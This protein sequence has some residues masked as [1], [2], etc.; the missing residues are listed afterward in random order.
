[1]SQAE[2]LSRDIPVQFS[3]D[4]AVLDRLVHLIPDELAKEIPQ[5]PLFAYAKTENLQDGFIEVSARDFARA[6]NSISW[7]LESN[8]GKPEAGSFPTIAYIGSRS[9]LTKLGEEDDLR[10]FLLAFG[11]VKVGYKM[12]F[13]SPRNSVAGHVNVL[14]KAKCDIF[15]VSKDIQIDHILSQRVMRRT[16]VVPELDYFL[17]DEPIAPYPYTKTFAE[18]REDPCLV[19][20]TTGSTGLPKPITWKLEILS[21][22]EAWRTIPSIDGYVPTTEVY[23]EATRAY[24]AMPL[25]HT[26]GIN[27]GI[28]MS[29]LLGITTVLGPANLLPNATFVNEMHKHAGIDASI[30]PPSTYEDLSQDPHAL[31][32][33][34]KLRYVLVCGAPLSEAV[35]D[36]LSDKTR[37]ISNFGAT[38][39]A[40][41]PRLSPAREDWAYF[42]WHPSHSGIQLREHSEGL[43]EL[44][45]ARKPELRS[46]QGIFSTFPEIQEYSMND[47]YSRHPDPSK[48]FL[49]RWQSRSDD[50][51][52]LSNGEK[53]A[54]ALMEAGL[55]GSPLVKG[56][57]VVG[58]GKFEPAALVDLGNSV[59]DK[60]EDRIA[61][62]ENLKTAIA[63]ANRYAP[64]HG[65]LDRYHIIIVDPARP[66]QYL[67]Q[68]KIQR[69]QTYELYKD[70]ID[71]L[72]QDTENLAP[73]MMLHHTRVDFG[74][75]MAIMQ[76]LE[77]LL[78]DIAG[79]QNPN[80]D[81]GLNAAGLDSLHIIRLVREFKIQIK[82]ADATQLKT[83]F[84][85]PNLIYQH[86][87]LKELADFFFDGHTG[88]KGYEIVTSNGEAGG[89]SVDKLE[90]M[91]NTLIKYVNLLPV[92]PM[93]IDPPPFKQHKTVL[94]T[95]STGSLGSYLLHQLFQ[96]PSVEYIFC[97]DRASGGAERYQKNRD[98]RGLTQLGSGR[99]EFIK[100]D[101]S[102]SKLGLDQDVYERLKRTVTHVV[103]SQWPVNFNWSLASFEP[104]IAG[105]VNLIQLAHESSRSAFILFL[106]S[107]AA[108]GGWRAHFNEHVPETP[109]YDLRAAA[110]TGYGQ[111]KLIA[112]CLLDRAAAVSGVRSASCRVGIIAG[113]VEKGELGFWSTNEY[114]PSIIV[115]SAHLGV[116]PRNFPSRDRVD[117]VPVDKL[118]RILTEI[119]ASASSFVGSGGMLR[120][121]TYHVVNPSAS[122]WDKDVAPILLDTYEDGSPQEVSF[123]EWVG[124]LKASADE[125]SKQGNIDIERNPA[126][127]LIDFY[128]NS[129]GMTSKGQSILSL[130]ASEAASETLRA[131]GPV[132]RDWLKWWMTQ[133]G[134]RKTST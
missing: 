71:R 9:W 109:I 95:G 101:L 88:K 27:I 40:C 54:P 1:M 106:S 80:P 69:R 104:S 8:F 5:H 2:P 47:L 105:V 29:L 73:E 33:L 131:L 48:H 55:R 72:Y 41:L 85:S 24:S 43:Y 122:S 67:G 66:I 98:K 116:F 7:Y 86:N 52:V 12:L 94:L 133:W 53:I 92:R 21:T 130:S 128:S 44:F 125:T 90:R 36:T 78:A 34:G 51:I 62:V 15:L 126:I 65:K 107:V 96:D 77:Q 76:W 60:M 75:R 26:S 56:A 16:D 115:S 59:P 84:V 64:A 114:I 102:E 57:M 79:I 83:D 22:Y 46:Y 32:E 112:E 23:Q 74:D 42:Y 25:F 31:N 58:H 110:G 82:L 3:K 97:L 123:D 20:H 87:S 30:G 13:L 10:Y 18:A 39:T 14:E 113:P 50:V 117:W 35:G 134:I 99:V 6:I 118:A 119:L 91:E 121:S 37:V 111:S 120:S 127:R 124:H 4:R 45:I 38:E 89:T 19:L 129:S 61:L 49:Y 17:R 132:S 81:D 63:E 103:H 28:T 93:V 11:A 68:G 100:A 108:V 70:D